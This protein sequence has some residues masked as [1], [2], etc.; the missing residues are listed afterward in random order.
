MFNAEELK[1]CFA[2]VG[3]IFTS[4]YIVIGT[5]KLY[6]SIHLWGWQKGIKKWLWYE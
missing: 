2:I 5:A 1:N 3:I 4:G 6:D